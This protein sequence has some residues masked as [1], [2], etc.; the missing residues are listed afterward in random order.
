[1]KNEI[2]VAN[3][4]H[5]SFKSAALAEETK[6][7]AAIGAD[8]RTRNIELA[9]S[10]GRIKSGKLYEEDG[11]KS[12]ADYAE[13]V[14][15]IAK[16]MAYQLANVGERFYLS[17]SE[18][19]KEVSSMLPPTSLAE[20]AGMTD[21]QIKERVTAGEISA[22]STQA[23]LREVAKSANDKPVKVL[24]QYVVDMIVVSGGSLHKVKLPCAT[25]D[26]AVQ[27]LESDFGFIET[28][29]KKFAGFVH[30]ASS[31]KTGNFAKLVLTETKKPKSKVKNKPKFT[32]AELKAM[33]AE[34]EA[35]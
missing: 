23:Q 25:L 5:V 12:V 1:M 28:E 26:E 33:L 6:K 15:G 32:I 18:T 27:K 4:A 20:I 9:K 2:T 31:S 19:A 10:F 14:F 29:T 35:E 8:I 11:Y 17:E 13:Q 24:K 22:E 30:F 34:A 21:E 16:S 7:I 3:P